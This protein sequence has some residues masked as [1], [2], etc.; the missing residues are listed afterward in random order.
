MRTVQLVI[1][2]QGPA[3]LSAALYTCRAGIETVIAG[4][5]PKIDGE[6][7]IDNYFG[8][9]E[10]VTGA[11]LM[12]QGR[13][14]VAR[15]GAEFV[16]ERVL[17]I[18]YGD[19]GTSFEVKTENAHFKACAV[20]VAT[21]VSRSKPGIPGL[22]EMDGKGVSYCVSC[23]GFF[24]RGKQVV[25]LGEGVHAANSALELTSYTPSVAI[26][27]NGKAPTITSEYME[28]LKEANI[29]ILEQ[30]IAR[31][32]GTNGLERVVFADGGSFD[33]FGLFVA[34]GEASSTDF[35]KTLGL[36][37]E[38]NSIKADLEQK[39]NIPGIFAA[40][41]CVGRFKQISVAVG[42]GALAGRAIISYVKEKCPKKPA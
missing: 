32:E 28:K 33:T 17:G 13:R 39:T 12:D 22:D 7:E 20:L 30:K 5:K 14:G 9:A 2:G 41:D 40:G 21:G 19:D 42:E 10:T 24:Y 27:T 4:L 11:Q 23:D 26:L 37:Q 3:G 18:H 16:N 29:P 1:V 35:A 6:Y 36:E 34:V 15:F 25:V 31:L 8:F 38:G